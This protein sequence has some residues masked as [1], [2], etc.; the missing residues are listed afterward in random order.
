LEHLNPT[1]A[2][3]GYPKESALD[4]IREYEGYDRGYYSGPFGYISRDSCDVYVAIRSALHQSPN[5]FSREIENNDKLSVFAG[6]GIVDGSTAQ[7][8]WTETSHKLNVISSLFPPTPFSLNQAP[9]ANMAFA[10]SLMEEIIRNGVTMFYICPGSRSTPLTTAVS[11]LQKKNH[12]LNI[13]N[14]P[15]M[16][17]ELDFVLLVIIE[18]QEELRV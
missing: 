8:E 14:Q 9:N 12:N 15:S 6:A 18:G 1:P 11:I 3:C 10:L 7:G 16:N 2:I 5:Q 4:L 13:V 17:V